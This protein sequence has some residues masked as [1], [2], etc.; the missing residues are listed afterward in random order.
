MSSSSPPPLPPDPDDLYTPPQHLRVGKMARL[1]WSVVRLSTTT[2]DWAWCTV[3]KQWLRYHPNFSSQY[4]QLLYKHC[5]MAHYVHPDGQLKPVPPQQSRFHNN[6]Q[7]QVLQAQERNNRGEGLRRDFIG[8]MDNIVVDTERRRKELEMLRELNTRRAME[9]SMRAMQEANRAS[10][11]RPIAGEEMEGWAQQRSDVEMTP[12]PQPQPTGQIQALQ[13]QLPVPIQPRPSKASAHMVVRQQKPTA[14]M[15]V[16]QPRPSTGT[17]DQQDPPVASMQVERQ[18]PVTHAQVEQRRQSP[19][20][21]LAEQQPPSADTNVKPQLPSAHVEVQRQLAG[22]EIETRQKEIVRPSDSNSV[23]GQPMRKSSTGHNPSVPPSTPNN[24]GGQTIQNSTERRARQNEEATEMIDDSMV[25]VKL[26]HKPSDKVKKIAQRA[27]LLMSRGTNLYFKRATFQVPETEDQKMLFMTSGVADGDAD[28]GRTNT[29]ELYMRAWAHTQFFAAQMASIGYRFISSNMR[30][31]S[32]SEA[33]DV[34]DWLI[35]ECYMNVPKDRIPEG[36][37]VMNRG[38]NARMKK[39]MNRAPIS[40]D[41]AIRER[42]T[43]EVVKKPKAAPVRTIRREKEDMT[44]SP[45]KPPTKREKG[46]VKKSKHIPVID[47]T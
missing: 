25:C 2:H 9:G 5:K 39:W 4:L 15:Q 44:T 45:K 30:R 35:L 41:V 28:S 38:E 11:A 32:T 19:A 16:V 10:S 40:K 36:A 43:T 27:Q 29:D 37:I 7:R 26:P 18:Q 46:S 12:L 23:A 47:L 31:T 3:C 17:E 1:V 21:T 42:E 22:M 24:S 34:S 20:T 33:P 13:R 6:A 8:A 14:S